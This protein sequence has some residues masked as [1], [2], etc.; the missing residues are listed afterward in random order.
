MAPGLRLLTAELAL[1]A[2]RRLLAGLTGLS[3]RLTVLLGLAAPLALVPTLLAGVARS[4]LASRCVLLASTALPAG[5]SLL[6]AL[7]LPAWWLAA[8]WL[9]A[10]LAP[11]SALLFASALGVAVLPAHGVRLG[12]TYTEQRINGVHRSRER[13][14]KAPVRPPPYAS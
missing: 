14:L 6:A 10:L 3:T 11:L 9:A 13:G 5:L 1:L 4:L 12:R 2:L 7:V 8:L